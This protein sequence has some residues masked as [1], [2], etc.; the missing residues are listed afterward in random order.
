MYQKKARLS[1]FEDDETATPG[2]PVVLFVG[3]L[4]GQW[5]TDS[6]LAYLPSMVG[7]GDPPTSSLASS[8]GEGKFQESAKDQTIAYKG[9]VST[10][11]Y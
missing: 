10:G 2:Q 9:R 3:N 11:R 8:S 1:V 7:R 5:S 6:G 4:M